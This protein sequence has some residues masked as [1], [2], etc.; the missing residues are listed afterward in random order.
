VKCPVCGA[1]TKV[2]DSRIRTE[3]VKRVRECADCLTR[4]RTYEKIDKTSINPYVLKKYL[5]NNLEGD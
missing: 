4:F 2:I 3:S 5:S 1:R